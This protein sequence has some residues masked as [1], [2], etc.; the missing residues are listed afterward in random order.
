MTIRRR[1]AEWFGLESTTGLIHRAWLRNQGLPGD[2]FDGR[3]VIGICNS[4]SE[5]TPCNAHLRDLAQHVKYGVLEAGGVPFEFPVMSLGETVMRPTTMLYRNL[6]SME[7]EESLRASPVDGV[8]LLCGCDKTTPAM[9]MGAASVDLPTAVVSGGPML[10]GKFQGRNIGSGTSLWTMADDVRAG[11]M[12]LDEMLSAEAGIS[13]SA[14]TCMT[15]GTASSMAAAMEVMGLALP[16][17]G[18]IP[19]VDSRRQMLARE[20]GRAIVGLVEAERPLSSIVTRASFENALRVNAALGGST[21]VVIHLLAIAGR[22][23]IS[24]TLDDIDRLNR[25]IPLLANIMPGGAYLME[26][27]YYAGGVAA[28]LRELGRHIDGNAATITGTLADTLSGVR[29]WNDDVIR[30]LAKPLKP[31]GGVAVLRGNIAPDGA[32]IKL[33]TIDPALQRHRGPAVVFDGVAD[34][35]A[36]IDDPALPVTADSVLIL[37]GAGPRGYPGMP[38]AGSLPIP[39]KLLEQGVTDML[40]LSDARMSGTSGGSVILHA[41]PEAAA[42][43]PIG[44]IEDGDIIELDVSARRLLLDVPDAE[45]ERRKR[46]APR[47]WAPV[48]TGG[49]ADLYT[50]HVEQADKGADFD[51]LKG[52]RGAQVP[53]AH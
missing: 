53:P 28:I 7:V 34:L 2:V 14:G 8:V 20:T 51:F 1:S 48:Y 25:D 30:P 40:R 29:N 18:A 4:W 46:A 3:P 50:A 45:L 11:R 31:E 47:S 36:R 22:L 41:A 13:R 26:D 6:A 17:N 33:A 9:V 19:A 39:R 49:Y 10:N 16:D 43:G 12:G 15:M 23:E 37:R 38:E 44:L 32:V 27:F 24:L 42:G 52:R 21:N 5:L 35:K